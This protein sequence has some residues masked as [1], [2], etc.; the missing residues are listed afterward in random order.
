MRDPGLGRPAEHIRRGA[1]VVE[2]DF[3]WRVTPTNRVVD[4]SIVPTRRI[5]S[6]IDAIERTVHDSHTGTKWRRH[7]ARIAR[8]T[9]DLVARLELRA[10]RYAYR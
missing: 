10:T 9:G 1:H 2:P 7:R 4:A 3:V 6:R 8:E 5:S